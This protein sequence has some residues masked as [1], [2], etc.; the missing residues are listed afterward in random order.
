MVQSTILIYRI[1]VCCTL[2]RS[3]IDIPDTA[4]LDDG[5]ASIKDLSFVRNDPAL[6]SCLVTFDF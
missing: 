3:K 5:V 1:D 6:S 2:R 4:C